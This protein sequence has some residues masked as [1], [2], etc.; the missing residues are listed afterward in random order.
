MLR[1]IESFKYVD[2]TNGYKMVDASGTVIVKYI[3][4]NAVG[5]TFTVYS[6]DNLIEKKT[7]IVPVDCVGSILE[8][9]GEFNR[10]Y[11]LSE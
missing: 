9:L 4:P 6:E 8:C 2:N 5:I 3:E 7:F 11:L 1:T 10:E